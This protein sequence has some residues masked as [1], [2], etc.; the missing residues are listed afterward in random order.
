M[1]A[2]KW[3]VSSGDFDAARELIA[4]AKKGELF[5]YPGIGACS[6]IAACLPMMKLRPF[7][8]LNVCCSS[9]TRSGSGDQPSWLWAG[10]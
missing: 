5:L 8:L 4:S 1:E 3:F 6:L 10:C 7:L 9:W 2:D